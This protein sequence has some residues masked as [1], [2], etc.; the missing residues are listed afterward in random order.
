MF[1]RTHAEIY[2]PDRTPEKE[3]LA[4]TTHLGIGAH[5][6]DLE[7][8]A[9]HG[10]AECYRRKT[11][12]FTSITC[13]DGAGSPRNGPYERM[14]LGQF[15][16][17]R[18][19]EQRSAARIGRYSA[20]IQL[21]YPSAEIRNL[22]NGNIRSDLTTVLLR[23]RPRWIYTHNLADRHETHLAVV[24][25]VLEALRSLG[26]KGWPRRLY[27]CEVWGSLDW[28]P[29]S[30]KVALDCSKHPLVSRKLLQV[31]RSQIGSGKRYDLATLG[32]R[33][34][35]ATYHHSESA[36]AA[37]GITFAMD[38]M[39]L[40]R[41]RRL[42]PLRYVSYMVERLERDLLSPLRALRS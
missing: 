33:Q 32:R 22:R 7:I 37:R 14:K 1:Y 27:G 35:N 2:V 4:R 24:L 36:D 38:L 39:P 18:R 3:A 28:L 11:R 6:D 34:A 5:A 19:R 25:H 42:N 16:E 8:M 17:T 12:W 23:T 29:G 40:L 13:G 9:Y 26:P 21:D 31:F 20:A 41:N 30:Q 15:K 10:I